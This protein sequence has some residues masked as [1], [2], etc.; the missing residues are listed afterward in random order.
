MPQRRSS[1]LWVSPLASATPACEGRRISQPG[2]E[3]ATNPKWG[4]G[5][6]IAFERGE[7]P[8]DIGIIAAD[9]G[10]ECFIEGPG[11]ARNPS[12]VASSFADPK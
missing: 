9:T 12:W 5:V 7:P 11:D 3:A 10:Q 8:R 4:P 6:L 2:P 1:T